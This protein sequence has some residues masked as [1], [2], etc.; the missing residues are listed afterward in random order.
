M[1]AAQGSRRAH[2]RSDAVHECWAGHNLHPQRSSGTLFR[3]HEHLSGAVIFPIPF[4]DALVG[5]QPA[6]RKRV[7]G[8][9]VNS[10]R[11]RR[12]FRIDLRERGAETG[13]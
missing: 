9:W 2:Y 12:F 10:C 1:M 13:R 8:S 6:G 11:S 3:A 7:Q 5:S 4:R